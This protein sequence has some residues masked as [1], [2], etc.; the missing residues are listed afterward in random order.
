M[1]NT[2]REYFAGIVNSLEHKLEVDPVQTRTARR[3]YALETARLG[4]RLYSGTERVAW[5]GVAAPFDLLNALDISSCFVEFVGANLAGSGMVSTFLDR[6]ESQGWA[7]DS[8]AYHRA[9]M[10]AALRGMMPEPDVLV[11]TSAPC[12]AGVATLENLARHFGK[13]LFVL[14]VPQTDS[15]EAV[16]LL[17]QQIK[18][19]IRFVAQRT[20]TTVEPARLRE[21]MLLSNQARELLV[22][23][24]HLANRVPS[25]VSSNDLRDLGIVLPLFFGTQ[26]AVDIARGYRD[27]LLRRVDTGERALPRERIRLMW[28]QNRIQFRTSIE[29]TI[30]HEFGAVIV[31]DELNDV[32]WEPV[33][34]DDPWEGLARR[35]SGMPLC[36]PAEQRIR[37]L[38]NLARSH[39]VDGVIH[40]CHWGCRQ[41]L[42]ARGL[43]QQGLGEIG[44]PMLDLAVDCIDTRA[45]SAGQVRTRMGAFL[46]MLAQRPS[47]WS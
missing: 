23:V 36:A 31:I 46:E 19:M 26:A 43:I 40:P 10:G 6:A 4:Q 30:A 12:S 17:A 32:T 18:E 1:M 2:M 7:P 38:R 33:D 29:R 45:F 37:H 27:E 9:V 15:P 44:V 11:A 35:M 5:C 34:P 3:K 42:G 14:H 20:G 25:P 47:P 8:C 28:I 41:S 22:Q 16:A 13:D 21:A 39:R 24:Y